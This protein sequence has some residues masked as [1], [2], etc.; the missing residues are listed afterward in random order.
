MSKIS[1]ETIKGWVDNKK[2]NQDRLLKIEKKLK[3]CNK[4]KKHFELRMKLI[5]EYENKLSI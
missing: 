4:Q 1:E 2:R 3:K 5:K